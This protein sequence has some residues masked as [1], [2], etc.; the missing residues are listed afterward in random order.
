MFVFSLED[1]APFTLTYC[2]LLVRKSS[3]RRISVGF[4]FMF[5][6]LYVIRGGSIGLNALEKS[7]N[8]SLADVPCL[9]RCWYT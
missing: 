4:T 7:T 8:N 1:E 3:T 5:L 9:S 2:D 6:S